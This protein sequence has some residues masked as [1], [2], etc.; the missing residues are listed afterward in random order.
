M[1]KKT[2][3]LFCVFLI[4]LAGFAACKKHSPYGVLIVD[5]MGMEHVIMTDANGVTVIDEDGNLIEVMTDS[6]N[7]KPIAVP[8]ENGTVSPE[9]IGQYQ[10]HAVT[11]PGIVE[12]GETV[13]DAFCSVTLPEGWEQIGNNYLIL[14]HT[15]TDAR[16]MIHSDIG[17]TVTAAIRQLTEEIEQLD[18]KGGYT[19]EDIVIDGVTVTRTQYSLEG[20]TVISYLLVTGNGKVCRISC[21]V[22]SDKLET[23]GVDA[24]V[25]SIHFK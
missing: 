23:S 22:A 20:L 14:C 8:T 4:V 6:G 3:A 2:I 25:R 17:G 12:N 11:F 1:C 7:K 13:E 5:Q 10:T 19:Q 9:Q 16:V 21:T 15:A 18:P 24:L